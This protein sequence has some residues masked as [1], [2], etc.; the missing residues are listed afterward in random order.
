MDTLYYDD[1]DKSMVIGASRYVLQIAIRT[2]EYTPASVRINA[3]FMATSSHSPSGSIVSSYA[4][5]R[6]PPLPGDA[7]PLTIR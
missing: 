5:Q 4:S 1:W 7:P 6:L 3:R 2:I